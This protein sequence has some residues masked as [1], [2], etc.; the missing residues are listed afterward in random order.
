MAA[1]LT[2]ETGDPGKL[3][4]YTRLHYFGN[5]DNTIEWTIA[6]KCVRLPGENL[7]GGSSESVSEF[8]EL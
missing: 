5:G 6:K 7:I 2:R 4:M 3:I 1:T 8:V